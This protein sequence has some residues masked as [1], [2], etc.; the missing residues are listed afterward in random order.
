M[1]SKVLL[2]VGFEFFF[3]C[4]LRSV[5]RPFVLCEIY[6]GMTAGIWSPYSLGL[7]IELTGDGGS[8]VLVSNLN[9][10]DD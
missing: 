4:K 1:D 3:F 9:V 10:S 7:L 8:R 6:C 2:E 5:A